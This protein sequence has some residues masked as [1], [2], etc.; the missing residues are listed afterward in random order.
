MTKQLL[1]S[2]EMSDDDDLIRRLDIVHSYFVHEGLGHGEMCITIDQARNRIKEQHRDVEDRDPTYQKRYEAALR[3]WDVEV[4]D[5]R[6]RL[7]AAEKERDDLRRQV[8]CWVA[9]N[10][11]GRPTVADVLEP[12]KASQQTCRHCGSPVPCACWPAGERA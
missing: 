8:E 4:N 11:Q 10:E 1:R 5:L 9:W 7:Q 2:A 6:S 12:P 3:N